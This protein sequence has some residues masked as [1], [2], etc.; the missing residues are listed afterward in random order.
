VEENR[1]LLKKVNPKTGEQNK[2][3]FPF[4]DYDNPVT[5]ITVNAKNESQIAF[6][7]YKN[8]LYESADGGKSWT[9]LLAEGRIEQD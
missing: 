4:L 9:S 2:I 6:T 1:I 5:Y 8:D 7:T 3:V